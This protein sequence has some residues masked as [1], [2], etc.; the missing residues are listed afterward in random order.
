MSQAATR[1]RPALAHEAQ[2]L[3]AI[4]FQ[5]KAHWQYTPAQLAAWRDNLTVTPETIATYPTHVVEVDSAVVGFFVLVPAPA[6]WKLEQF[7]VAP[8]GMGR[9]IGRALLMRAAAVAARG[10]AA[11]LDIDADPNAEAFYAACGAIGIGAIPAPL[12]GQ[13]S[14]VRPQMRLSLTGQW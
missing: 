12:E 10:G 14:R 6:A 13:P 5:S 9:G 7:W 11:A 3:S 8:A 1:F 2:A 4:A